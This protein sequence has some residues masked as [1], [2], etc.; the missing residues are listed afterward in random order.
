[1]PIHQQLRFKASK[2]KQQLVALVPS[3]ITEF[4]RES[5]LVSGAAL[6]GT[7]IVA[8]GLIAAQ[9]I[10]KRRKKTTRRRVRVR[11]GR[12]HLHRH[13]HKPR[14]RRVVHRKTRRV[15]KHRVRK[16][17]DI[18]HRGKKRGISLKAIRASIASPRTPEP[19][20]RGLRKLLRKRA[21]R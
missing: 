10:R 14:R 20:K 17:L 12:V 2:I 8:G 15:H 21:R 7:A 4:A 16:G 13:I 18:I 1:M 19:L 11:R 5:P 3:Q 6:G 9:Q